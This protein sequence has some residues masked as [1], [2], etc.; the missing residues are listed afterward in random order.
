MR[1]RQSQNEKYMNILS[2]LIWTGTLVSPF[3]LLPPLWA[4]LALVFIS[5]IQPILNIIPLIFLKPLTFAGKITPRVRDMVIGSF[6]S[7]VVW[8]L[9]YVASWP[10][11]LA[12]AVALVYL[13]NQTARAVKNHGGEE[14]DQ[15]IGFMFTTVIFLIVRILF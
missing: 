4:I 1:F 13:F 6:E 2:L 3:L 12:V 15:L 7:V 9:S 8:C 5:I 14:L 10:S 11:N